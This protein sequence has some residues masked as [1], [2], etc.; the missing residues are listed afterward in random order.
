MLQ[1]QGISL[2]TR[3]GRDQ[4]LARRVWSRDLCVGVGGSTYQ[5]KQQQQQREKVISDEDRT[6]MFTA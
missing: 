6:E 5:S 4:S 3:M 1:W 2:N